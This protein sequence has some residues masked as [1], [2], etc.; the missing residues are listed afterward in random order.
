MYAV[1]PVSASV[2]ISDLDCGACSTY[3]LHLKRIVLAHW[4]HDADVWWRPV[5]SRKQLYASAVDLSGSEVLCI[6]VMFEADHCHSKHG[7]SLCHSPLG[8]GVV[9]SSASRKEFVFLVQATGNLAE[10]EAYCL[11]LLDY[12][13]P[14][15]EKAKSLLREIRSLQRHQHTAPPAEANRAT[16]GVFTTPVPMPLNALAHH[17]QEPTSP[18]SDAG[19]SPMSGS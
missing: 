13:A 9:T 7:N 10:A 4:A 8:W 12:G 19:A 16:T 17:Q 3:H 1:H 6:P 14:S 2:S 18:S 5:A 11:Q 15:K